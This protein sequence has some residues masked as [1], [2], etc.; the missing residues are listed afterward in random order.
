MTNGGLLT[1]QP[2][3]TALETVQIPAV[4][5]DLSGAVPQS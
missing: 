2:I 3:P 5:A 1:I 4:R